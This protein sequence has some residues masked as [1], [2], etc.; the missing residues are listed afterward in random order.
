MESLRDDAQNVTEKAE[1]CNT[2]IILQISISNTKLLFSASSGLFPQTE[3]MLQ[4][5]QI[6][7]Q[8]N[9]YRL[10]WL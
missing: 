3:P 5:N 6:V 7:G 4:Q 1:N 10:R 9:L 8:T 2:K